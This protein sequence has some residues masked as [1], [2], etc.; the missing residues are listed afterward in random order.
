[1]RMTESLKMPF[2]VAISTLVFPLSLIQLSLTGWDAQG[3]TA[4]ANKKIIRLR[5]L[6]WRKKYPFVKD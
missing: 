1:M 6:D 3:V 2:C 4:I 5:G